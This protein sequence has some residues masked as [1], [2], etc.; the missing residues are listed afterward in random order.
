MW[1]GGEPSPF[2]R[3]CT[4]GRAQSRRRCDKS[5]RSPGAD[6]GRGWARSRSRCGRGGPGPG[7][8]AA[9]LNAPASRHTAALCNA[10]SGT[11]RNAY[12]PQYCQPGPP[13]SSPSTIRL[14]LP[15]PRPPSA[16]CAERGRAGPFARLTNEQRSVVLLQRRWTSTTGRQ[17]QAAVEWRMVHAA[18]C[19][20]A[21]RRNHVGANGR[22]WVGHGEGRCPAA[23]CPAARC[24]CPACQLFRERVRGLRA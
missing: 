5:Q 1:A 16:H 24:R 11:S 14:G 4:R 12:T 18:C 7:A 22:A 6:V 19:Y 2:R 23:R 21:Q 10:T 15:Q 13:S 9:G 17:A 8:D 3:R 20:E